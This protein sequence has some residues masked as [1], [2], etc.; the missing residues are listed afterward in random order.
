[1]CPGTCDDAYTAHGS[2]VA[3]MDHTLRRLVEAIEQEYG[4]SN[5]AEGDGEAIGHSIFRQSHG[6]G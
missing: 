6:K 5:K 4:Y 2:G 1:V 3:L